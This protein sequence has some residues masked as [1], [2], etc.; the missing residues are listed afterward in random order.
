LEDVEVQVPDL[1]AL[2][3]EE[4]SKYRSAFFAIFDGHAGRNAA[5]FCAENLPRLIAEKIEKPTE[6]EH[7]RKAIMQGFKDADA[8]FLAMA[9]ERGFK[10]GCTAVTVTLL[11][12]VMF[13]G[14]VG[15]S[16][17]V[18]ARRER[19]EESSRLKALSLTRDHTAMQAKE[20]ERIVKAGG[21]VENNR[22]NGIMEVSRSIGDPQLKKAGVS[23]SPE[24]ERVTLCDRDEF[25]LLACD[26]LWRV[27]DAKEAIERSGY[28][29][30]PPPSSLLPPPLF[31]P[32]APATP[33]VH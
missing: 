13:V 18:L 14:W 17:A 25:L 27:M 15:D 6:N 31:R 26:G 21:F 16:K 19:E 23:S 20:R 4:L 3:S 12:D 32:V 30:L 10:D 7:V 2:G 29:L 22:V 28:S 24:I 33:R 11:R 9:E 5:E 1:S 8:K